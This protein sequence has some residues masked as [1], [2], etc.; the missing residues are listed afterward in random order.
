[1][2]S[3][4]RQRAKNLVDGVKLPAPPSERALLSRAISS[5]MR[6]DAVLFAVASAG[7][8]LR[9]DADQIVSPFMV[10]CKP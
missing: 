10:L 4:P 2:P 1:M 6:M 8:V 3:V 9:S 7:Q 5:T